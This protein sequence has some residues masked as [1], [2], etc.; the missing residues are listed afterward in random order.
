MLSVKSLDAQAPISEVHVEG[1]ERCS[2]ESVMA[3]AELRLNQV[4][5]RT[6][7]DAA[8]QRLVDTGFFLA[9]NYR[10]QPRK[11]DGKNTYSLTLEVMEETATLPVVIDLAGFD[12][13]AIAKEL[14]ASYPLIREKIPN[15]ER[16]MTYART[17][18]EAVLKRMGRAEEVTAPV[19]SNLTTRETWVVFRLANAPK[20]A[21][22]TFTGNR[23]VDSQTLVALAERLL[24]GH[25]YSERET[26]RFL[27]RNITPLYEERAML[28]ATFPRV[29]C[30]EPCTGAVNVVVDVNEGTVWK[31]GKVD[32]AGD[33]LPAD[34]MR[35]AAKFPEG[36]LADW[37]KFM[38][39]VA[40]METPLRRDGY[41]AVSSQP[42]RTFRKSEPIVDVTVQVTKGKRY[43]LGTIQ[44]NGLDDGERQRAVQ[45]CKLRAGDPFDELYIDEYTK[46]VFEVPVRRPKSVARE[47][48][49][50]AGTNV[51]DVLISY[52]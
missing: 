52:R 14:A 36:Q 42:A 17:A 25:D 33:G 31:L 41:I 15:N 10:Y 35:T 24:K 5:G 38:A 45:L 7:L 12:S 30:V 11:V 18:I 1:C 26:R 4:A 29:G 23:V 6:E 51:V 27:E 39:A 48:R 13:A 16:A 49:P 19:E 22:V 50:R 34:A 37:K 46:E 40:A 43:V 20:V 3:A 8:M 28:N 44:L 32:I 2:T 47:L 9:T 21:T